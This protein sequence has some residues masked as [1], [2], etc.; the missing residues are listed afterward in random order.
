M[1]EV[2]GGVDLHVAL[3]RASRAFYF[4]RLRKVLIEIS[5]LYQGQGKVV[6]YLTVVSIYLFRDFADKRSSTF[7]QSSCLSVLTIGV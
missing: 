6:V 1:E 2:M 7:S 4:L 5:V 3:V